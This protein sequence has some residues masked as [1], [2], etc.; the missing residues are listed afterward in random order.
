[1]AQ[2]HDSDWAA[3]Q[4]VD[5]AQLD[6]RRFRRAS[7]FTVLPRVDS[8]K[9]IGPRRDGVAPIQRELILKV[10]WNHAEEAAGASRRMRVVPTG[11]TVALKWD[12]GACLALV[13]SDVGGA[14]QRRDR[15]RL[16]SQ[17]A[18]DGVLEPDDDAGRRTPWPG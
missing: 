15:D 11:A 12:T 2:L 3:Y 9:V 4:Y 14:D 5:A 6:A 7:S 17:L 13:H 18:E 10:A 1:M 8:T 16:L